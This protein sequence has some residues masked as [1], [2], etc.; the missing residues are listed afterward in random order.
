MRDDIE[1]L[2][3]VYPRAC[4]VIDMCIAHYELECELMNDDK[5]AMNELHDVIKTLIA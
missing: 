4:D 1:R 2:R 3:K 5:E